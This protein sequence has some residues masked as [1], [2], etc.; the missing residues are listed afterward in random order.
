MIVSVIL[1][2][3]QGIAI[4]TRE[5]NPFES[6]A[7]LHTTNA[8]DNASGRRSL[9]IGS[10]GCLSVVC[11]FILF[12]CALMFAKFDLVALLLATY[13]GMGVAA[14]TAALFGFIAGFKR[15]EGARVIFSRPLIL[16][17]ILN[18]ILA[19]I[20]IFA[21]GNVLLAFVAA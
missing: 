19:L 18:S 11:I 6:P 13:V 16:G 12:F 8:V 1:F 20:A 14:G 9:V 17:L 21:L 2:K 4:N 10:V 7:E 5:E 15:Q 3:E